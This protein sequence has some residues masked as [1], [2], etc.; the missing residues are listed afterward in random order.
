MNGCLLLLG[1]ADPSCPN[2]GITS[3]GDVS[4]GDAD[5]SAVMD[6]V[7]LDADPTGTCIHAASITL[8]FGQGC[9]ISLQ[10]DGPMEEMAVY[11]GSIF[12][13]EGCG[14]PAS[15]FSV[16]DVGD[17]T[18]SAEG[19]LFSVGG[20]DSVCFDGTVH[21]ALDL[22]LEDDGVTVPVTGSV[23]GEG[24]ELAWFEAGNCP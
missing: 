9:S 5:R 11:A 4:F 16:Q 13:D 6:S 18:I 17:S 7:N 21:V 23:T 14:L 12:G 3:D 8:E 22:V 10:A 19:G 1:N 20:D 15:S 2:D 24:I